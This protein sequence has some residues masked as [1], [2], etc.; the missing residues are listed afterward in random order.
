LIGELL[1][2]GRVSSAEVAQLEPLLTFDDPML[3]FMEPTRRPDE[4]PPIPRREKY[5]ERN[6]QWL[7]RI[8]DTRRL[9]RPKLQNGWRVIA[10][11]TTLRILD[12]E[13]PTETR[14]SVVCPSDAVPPK[15]ELLTN[16]PASQIDAYWDIDVSG[17]VG[18][19]AIQN[20]AHMYDTIGAKWIGFNPKVARDV[21]WH[22][23]TESMLS[24]E[25]GSGRILA[26]TIWWADG[27]IQHYPP[28]FSD[29]IAE[30]WLVVVAP[31]A[32]EVLNRR[33]TTL[34]RVGRIERQ[35]TDEE[36]ERHKT[37]DYID[38]A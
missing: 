11:N 10:E 5:S 32:W 28:A 24:W 21:G 31:E 23:G 35:F 25:D 33:F 20:D 12:W 30:G 34:V 26:K 6:E 9:V 14:R 15:E 8:E 3:L 22:P 13:V 36:R 4:V 18:S 37:L 16:V 19:L 38:L 29:E 1:D 7:E 2:A 27:A 17:T